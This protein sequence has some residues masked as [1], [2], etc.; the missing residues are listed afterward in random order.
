M[1]GYGGVPQNFDTREAHTT[2]CSSAVH[3][4]RFI[5]LVIVISNFKQVNWPSIDTIYSTARW[6]VNF[7]IRVST[8]Q[9]KAAAAFQ[10]E[11]CWLTGY[12]KRGMVIHNDMI[13]NC[14]ISS[15][16]MSLLFK[17]TVVKHKGATG[18]LPPP[19]LGLRQALDRECTHQADQGENGNL[20]L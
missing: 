5:L 7:Q 10:N 12:V 9:A 17:Y 2:Y 16:S 1:A 4:Y 14:S 3:G 6:R 19:P 20:Q 8:V 18:H 15:G 13:S 11:V